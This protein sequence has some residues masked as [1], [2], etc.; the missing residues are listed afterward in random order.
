M[1]NIVHGLVFFLLHPHTLAHTN[2]HTYTRCVC[3]CSEQE[4]T[5]PKRWWWSMTA[6]VVV[7]GGCGGLRLNSNW[8]ITRN[9]RRGHLRVE[10]YQAMSTHS[11]ED[12]GLDDGGGNGGFSGGSKV[13]LGS[14]RVAAGFPH[15][16]PSFPLSISSPSTSLSWSIFSSLGAAIE[17]GFLLGL[18]FCRAKPTESEDKAAAR[19]IL[20]KWNFILIW[21]KWSLHEF[22][23]QSDSTCFNF[24]PNIILFF[25]S[26]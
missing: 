15:G 8:S 13:V 22:L 24:H 1:M 21:H 3:V 2:S 6:V 17:L 26:K 10:T 11:E 4:A 19:F 25:Q 14:G 23:W 9:R 5:T 20:S 18:R 16:S 7:H 12:Y